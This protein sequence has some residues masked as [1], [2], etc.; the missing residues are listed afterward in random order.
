MKG[1]Y[2]SPGLL[3]NLGFALIQTGQY[4]AAEQYLKQAIRQKSDL[5]DAYHNL[6]L[7]YLNRAL[8]GRPLPKEAIEHAKRAV[9]IGSPS[10]DLYRDVA[11]LF[12]VAAP[13]TPNSCLWQ[14]DTPRRP[15]TAG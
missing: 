14:S 8:A 4:D 3:N 13:T 1:G 9:E 12:A 10:T 11:K 7:V 5:Q 15:W 2:S 6:V